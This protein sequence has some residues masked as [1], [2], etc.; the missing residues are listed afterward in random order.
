MLQLK[1]MLIILANK[2]GTVLNRYPDTIIVCTLKVTRLKHRYT[3]NGFGI[4][5]HQ[6]NYSSDKVA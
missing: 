6:R 3:Q 5:R 2:I 1:L 4:R